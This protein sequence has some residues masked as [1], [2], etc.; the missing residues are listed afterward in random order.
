VL[1]WSLQQEDPCSL[2]DVLARRSGMCKSFEAETNELDA[3]KGQKDARDFVGG[4]WCS[5]PLPPPH[6]AQPALFCHLAVRYE[7]YCASVSQLGEGR[8]GWGGRWV[9]KGAGEV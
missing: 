8:V 9:S 1:E 4:G 5:P 2:E 6:C 3:F 7:L